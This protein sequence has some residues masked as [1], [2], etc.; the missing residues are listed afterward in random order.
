MP[1]V[2]STETTTP[3]RPR[4]ET[5]PG[6]TI[7][8]L[9]ALVRLQGLDELDVQLHEMAAW[10]GPE[11]G[12]LSAE[13]SGVARGS[14]VAERGARHL[15]DLDG[16]YL[17]PL[18]LFAVART[19]D[20]SIETTTELAVAVELVHSATLLHDDVV[21][22]G[23]RRRG[24]VTARVVYGNAA[25]IFAGDFLLIEALRRIRRVGIGDLLDG[26]LE[27]IDRMIWAE[28]IQ[29]ESRG[30]LLRDLDRYLAVVEGKTAALFG[31]AATAGARAAGLRPGSARRLGDYGRHLGIAFQIVDDLLD[32]T[33]GAGKD[34][35]ADLREGKS[36]YPLLWALERDP[37]LG[38]RLGAQLA[39]SDGIAA[40]EL[41]RVLAAI[42]ASGAV[43]A[44]RSLAR[45]HTERAVAALA[46]IEDDVDTSALDTLKALATAAL[47]RDR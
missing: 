9:R 43:E 41:D 1:A 35:G 28:S 2:H 36:T 26:M 22:L 23:E 42:A 15:L 47:H 31:W 45:E 44:T 5:T 11:L 34:L 12:A 4:S 14:C 17:R 19:G 7:D 30:T 29:L 24:R 39:H 21:D 13:L 37:A 10:I 3:D 20:P 18:T 27:V 38:D 46:A 6:T 16:K 8:R 25:S 40:A 32:V 33:G